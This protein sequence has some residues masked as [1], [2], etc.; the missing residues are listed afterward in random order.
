[1][2][3]DFT[4]VACGRT[5]PHRLAALRPWELVPALTARAAARRLPLTGGTRG[6]RLTAERGRRT[7]AAYRRPAARIASRPALGLE[8]NCVEEL[9]LDQSAGESTVL[10]V[11]ARQSRKL[12]RVDGHSEEEPQPLVHPCGL[13]SFREVAD[14]DLG[15]GRVKRTAYWHSCRG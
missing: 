8:D 10:E 14:I 1:M 9:N 6:E 5:K 12:R 15:R 13:W 2:R 11:V 4:K 3:R 7:D